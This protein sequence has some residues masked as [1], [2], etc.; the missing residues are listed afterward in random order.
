MILDEPDED[1]TFPDDQAVTDFCGNHKPKIGRPRI[2]DTAR[3][4]AMG[5]QV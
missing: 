5:M 2:T 3:N 4:A 1:A